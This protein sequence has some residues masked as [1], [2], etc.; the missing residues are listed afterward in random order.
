MKYPTLLT[1]LLLVT[2]LS[3]VQADCGAN[4]D[5]RSVPEISVDASA[6][7]VAHTIHFKVNIPAKEFTAK[8]QAAPLENLLPGTSKLPGVAA[9]HILQNGPFGKIGSR[10]L[11]C[12][13]DGNTAVEEVISAVAEKSF[14]YKVWNYSLFQARP[15]EY[16]VG[17]FIATPIDNTSADITWTYA[18]KLRDNRFPGYLGGIGRWLFAKNFVDSDYAEFM[19][20]SGQTMTRY[21]Q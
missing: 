9:T 6:P 5:A 19:N 10:R 13:R 8:L 18:F 14:K 7:F 1:G 3:A 12:L 17:E 11:I 15:I 16:A 4:F 21:W 20:I 2:H